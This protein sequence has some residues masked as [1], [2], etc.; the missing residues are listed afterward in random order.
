LLVVIGCAKRTLE[1]EN[2]A[3]C[4]ADSDC[5]AEQKCEPFT[6]PGER[7]MMV[8]PCMFTF[9]YCTTSANCTNGQVCWPVGRNY[10]ALPPGCFPT[11]NTC[12]PPCT[13]GTNAC[14]TDEVCE[15]NGEC[16]L[17]ACDEASGMACPDHWRCDRTAAE[18]EAV[19]PVNGANEADSPNYSRDI[20]RGCARI[21]CDEAGGFTC[22][23]GWVCDPASASDPS[24]CAPLP[25]AQA[26]HCSDDT[27]FICEP[28]SSSPRP[29]GGDAHGCV[30]KNCEEGFECTRLVNGID[31]GY[32]DFD[33]PLADAFGCA[34][35]R[36]DEPGS[37]CNTSQICEPASSFA[38]T[39]GCRPM[40]CDEGTSCGTLTCDPSHPD[41][42]SRGCVMPVGSGSGGSGAG[43]GGS[44]SGQSGT[45]AT[46]Q[47]GASNGGSAGAHGGNGGAG[48]SSGSASGGISGADGSAGKAPDEM[49][50]RC[51]DR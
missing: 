12:G 32:C 43:N 2:H 39:R 16:R 38:D 7:P 21:G 13:S 17:P 44:A 49:T 1:S 28:T 18:T 24:G 41:A 36:C 25:C 50:G 30:L 10:M 20:T 22:K 29:M 42:D 5:A 48:G 40:N 46:G 37:T 47:G 26:G 3:T 51:V 14:F 4:R 35:R 27:R 33:G 15:T 45:G 11:G 9:A 19:Q 6:S 8:A 23:D 34:R 31:V